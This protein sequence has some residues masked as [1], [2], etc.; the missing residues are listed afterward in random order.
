MSLLRTS[1]RSAGGPDSVSA[2]WTGR[3]GAPELI[4]QA[5]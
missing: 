1:S 5:P 3:G 2:A 4:C